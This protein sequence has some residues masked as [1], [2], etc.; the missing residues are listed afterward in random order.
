MS[1]SQHIS[2]LQA[3]V[4]S[5]LGFLYCKHFS[6][7]PAAKLTLIQ[8]TILPTLD[9]GDIIYR[10]AGLTPPYLRYL[11]QPSS[12]T[13]NT[14]SASHILL[15]VPKAH[16]S[17]CHSSFQFAAASD[18]NELQKTL[19][20]PSLHSKTQ[21]WTLLLTVW[22][23]CVIYYCLYLLAFLCCCLCPIMLVPCCVATMLLSCAVSTML[24][25]H[26]LLPCYVVVLGRSLCSVVVSCPIFVFLIPAPIPAGV[27]LPFGR[28]SL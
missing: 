4:K 15:K 6:F 28:P 16:T 7:T 24:C 23:L 25:C 14:G 21:S 11:L 10:S 22:L 20:S 27:L 1:F 2:K 9:Y 18:W 12:S 8:M 17:L 26:V 5:R 19:K 3:K 13:C